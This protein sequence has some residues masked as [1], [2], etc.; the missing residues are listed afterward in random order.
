MPILKIKVLAESGADFS[1]VTVKVT[2]IDELHTNPQGLAQFLIDDAAAF[3][4]SI[5][6][7]PTWSGSTSALARQETFKQ[8]G[9]GFVRVTTL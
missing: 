7:Q 3:D 5:A 4:L 8:S 9:Q 6:G 2:G 1:G